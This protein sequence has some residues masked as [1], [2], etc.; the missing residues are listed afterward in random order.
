MINYAIFFRANLHCFTRLQRRK[1]TLM[2]FNRQFECKGIIKHLFK[3]TLLNLSDYFDPQKRKDTCVILH[4]ALTPL[5]TLL[6]SEI[7]MASQ[8]SRSK[9]S[10]VLQGFLWW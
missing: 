8:I 2:L 3:T 6:V 7:K 4:E 10:H 9:V 5:T 1:T